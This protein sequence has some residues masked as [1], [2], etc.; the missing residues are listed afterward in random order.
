MSTTES[1]RAAIRMHPPTLKPGVEVT[2]RA[3]DLAR[4]P[5]P[6]FDGLKIKVTMHQ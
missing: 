6:N 3:F 1:E 5:D 2:L 4:Y